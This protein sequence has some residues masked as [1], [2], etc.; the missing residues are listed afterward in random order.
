MSLCPRGRTAS[1]QSSVG[2]ALSP[3]PLTLVSAFPTLKT[4]FPLV[5][6]QGSLRKEFPTNIGGSDVCFFCRKRVY[7]MERLSAEGKFF[8]RSCFKCEYCGTTLRLSSYA[9]DVED[10]KNSTRPRTSVEKCCFFLCFYAY[11]FSSF[12]SLQGSFTASRTTVTACLATPRESAPLP[13]QLLPPLRYCVYSLDSPDL[14]IG[15]ACWLTRSP[16][17]V[18]SAFA[19]EPGAPSRTGGRGRPRKGGG[20]ARHRAP[21][22]R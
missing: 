5:L 15:S 18:L 19:G 20:G 6:P 3:S 9:F 17:P 11:F 4:R 2:S 12:F 13:P 10:G 8:H 22:L 21:A 7:V 1:R 14:L 16:L